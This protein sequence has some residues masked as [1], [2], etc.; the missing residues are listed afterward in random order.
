M[1]YLKYFLILLFMPCIVFAK[2]EVDIK[3]IQFIEKTGDVIADKNPTFD[4]LNINLDLNFSN[5]NESV[6]YKIILENTTDEDFTIATDT[7]YG[8]NDYIKYFTS[9]KDDSRVIKAN[10]EEEIILIISYVKDIPF[11]EFENG[12]YNE[13]GK[14][15][16]NFLTNEKEIIVPISKDVNNVTSEEANNPITS[17]YNIIIVIGASIIAIIV[18]ILLRHGFKKT[19]LS[20]ILIALLSIPLFAY[21]LRQIRLDIEATIVIKDHCYRFETS[22]G[23][24]EEDKE[25][26]EICIDFAKEKI[27]EEIAWYSKYGRRLNEEDK[28]LIEITK[29]FFKNGSYLRVYDN[30]NQLLLNYT[31]ESVPKMLC[32]VKGSCANGELWDIVE[33]GIR[34]ESDVRIEISEDLNVYDSRD[35][36]RFQYGDKNFVRKYQGPFIEDPDIISKIRRLQEYDFDGITFKGFEIDTQDNHLYHAIWDDT[37]E[38]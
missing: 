3:D 34:D 5:V 14:V 1:K 9:F 24:F 31:Y 4:G 6:K 18:I 37:S 30:N 22:L 10:S 21:A 29:D 11:A 2:N 19:S 33:L 23:S 8:K 7:Q 16:I 25:V 36:Y 15:N 27:A 26:K 12:I 17:T 32:P 35:I 38:K 28:L 13:K 20:I